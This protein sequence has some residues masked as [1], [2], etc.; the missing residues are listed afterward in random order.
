MYT[1]PVLKSSGLFKEN[2]FLLYLY[3]RKKNCIEKM[4]GFRLYYFD[5][6]ESFQMAIAC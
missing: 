5:I 2:N 4:F 1:L 3:V 6:E